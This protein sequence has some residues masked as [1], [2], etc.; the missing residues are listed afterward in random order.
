MS[1]PVSEHLFDSDCKLTSFQRSHTFHRMLG[2]AEYAGTA[3]SCS[4][5]HCCTALEGFVNLVLRL[6]MEKHWMAG[7]EAERK[8]PYVIK[9]RKNGLCMKNVSRIEKGEQ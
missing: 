1:K 2:H 5:V 4:A 6:A 9:V 8:F 3:H 7:L